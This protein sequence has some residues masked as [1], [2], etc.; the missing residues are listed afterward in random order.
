MSEGR[1]FV[2]VRVAGVGFTDETGSEG[3]VWLT[4]EDGRTFAMR[5]FSGESS[6]HMQR[7]SRGDRSSIPSVFNMI[8]ELA[9]REG[10]HLGGIEVY[11]AGDVLRADLQFLGKGRDLLLTGDRASDAIALA[12]LYEA[13]M[14]IHSSLFESESQGDPHT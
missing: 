4:S 5:A 7:F 12:M 10:L 9:D 11:P 8:E 6:A 14:M 13:P 1:E 2:S 3:L